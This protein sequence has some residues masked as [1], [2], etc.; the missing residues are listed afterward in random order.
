MDG[1]NVRIEESIKRQEFIGLADIP[2]TY[3]KMFLDKREWVYLVDAY[4]L[5]CYI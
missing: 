3:S 5:V 2:V 4:I 1:E